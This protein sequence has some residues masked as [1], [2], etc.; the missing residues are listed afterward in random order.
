MR[1]EVAA[2]ATRHQQVTDILTAQAVVFVV[3]DQNVGNTSE[4]L[5][6]AVGGDVDVAGLGDVGFAIACVDHHHE[7]GVAQG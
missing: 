4:E 3:N 1:H 2:R 7:V 5:R 6:Q